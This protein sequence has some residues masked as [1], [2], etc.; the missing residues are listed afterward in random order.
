M[1]PVFLI[2]VNYA[3]TALPNWLLARVI[4]VVAAI[5]QAESVVLPLLLT[6][7]LASEFR[8]R[9]PPALKSGKLSRAYRVAAMMRCTGSYA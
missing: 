7:I 1:C 8:S 4:G 6:G 2:L 3:T 9:P 5:G